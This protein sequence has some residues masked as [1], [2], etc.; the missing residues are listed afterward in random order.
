MTPE[1]EE[2]YLRGKRSVWRDLHD[3]ARE[4]LALPSNPA[5]QLSAARE[6]LRMLCQDHDLPNDWPENLSLVD[7]ISNINKGLRR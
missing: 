5:G 4:E 1:E 2:A 7:V 3:R 6:A